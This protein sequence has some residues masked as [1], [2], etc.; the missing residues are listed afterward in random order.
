M[1]DFVVPMLLIGLIVVLLLCMFYP[2]WVIHWNP[3]CRNCGSPKENLQHWVGREVSS[4]IYTRWQW[5]PK[6]KLPENVRQMHQRQVQEEAKKLLPQYL[7]AEFEVRVKAQ[8]ELELF[9][10]RAKTT[11]A[12]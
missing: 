12:P 11:H 2:A 6:D 1:L 8:V 5:L 4:E 9:L 7:D 10:L 3:W